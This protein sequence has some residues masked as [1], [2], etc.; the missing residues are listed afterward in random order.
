VLWR[1]SGG[2]LKIIEQVKVMSDRTCIK[3][4]SLA[5][6]VAPLTAF[7]TSFLALVTFPAAVFLILGLDSFLAAGAFLGL[8]AAFFVVPDFLRA[9]GA[10]SET[11]SKTLGLELPVLERVCAQR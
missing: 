1:K 9:A 7:L 2:G 11:V 4:T 6:L 5:F 3:L 8:T 10:G